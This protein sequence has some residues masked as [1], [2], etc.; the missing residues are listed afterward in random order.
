M[1][2]QKN[3]RF[4]YKSGVSK[5]YWEIWKADDPFSY[6]FTTHWG[7]IGTK[8]QQKMK[9]FSYRNERDAAVEK[10]ISQKLKKGYIEVISTLGETGGSKPHINMKPAVKAV[11]KKKSKKES[12]KITMPD[13]GKPKVDVPPIEE[14][15]DP[16]F[17]HLD[18]LDLE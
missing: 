9:Q 16:F 5:K 10:L 1:A 14:N 6:K 2:D 3:R 17:D 8:G 15:D 12:P 11:K 4:E 13:V 7:R 18:A